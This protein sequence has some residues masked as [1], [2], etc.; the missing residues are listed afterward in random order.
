LC[1]AFYDHVAK[2]AYLEVLEVDGS[3]VDSMA[4][5]KGLWDVAVKPWWPSCGVE[6]GEPDMPHA[7]CFDRQFPL[8]VDYGDYDRQWLIP[9]DVAQNTITDLIK[10]TGQLVE[11]WRTADNDG[12]C[13][14]E[15]LE[16]VN[17]VFKDQYLKEDS[18][19][20][21]LQRLYA[22]T[23]NQVAEATSIS[24][25]TFLS[26]PIVRWPLYNFVLG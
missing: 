3:L 9:S 26:S 8:Y 25:E 15:V 22:S 17:A 7:T 1:Q 20:E 2:H 16:I 5:A 13:K 12:L 6:Y 23:A 4:K 24:T 18:T 19:T 11:L 14:P 10:Q 21:E